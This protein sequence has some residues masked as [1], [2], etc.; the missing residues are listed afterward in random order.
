M[1]TGFTRNTET[2]PK[3]LKSEK[4]QRHSGEVTNIHSFQ[5][6]QRASQILYP[7]MRSDFIAF[8]AYLTNHINLSCYEKRQY[9]LWITTEVCHN[10][11]ENVSKLLNLKKSNC[12]LKKTGVSKKKGIA[13]R[14]N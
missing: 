8:T 6:K 4:I 14:K 5:V 12:L 1:K 9:L 13:L 2:L 3:Y 7:E 10:D 11:T